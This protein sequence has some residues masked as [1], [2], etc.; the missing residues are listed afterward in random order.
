MKDME[1]FKGIIIA[2]RGI[3][4]NIHVYENTI[5]AF[6]KAIKR[7]IPIE[8][9]VH[10]LKDNKLVVFHDDNL[11]R[12]TGIK[13]EI[14]SLT[15]TELQNIKIK[16]KYSIPLFRDVLELV[17]GKVLLAIEIKDDKRVLDTCRE[18]VK[19]LD[20]YN[21]KF[22][23]QSFYPK[24][25]HWLKCYRKDYISGLLIP[26]TSPKLY[27]FII[28]KLLH[29]PILSP[30]F[31]ACSKYTLT[32]ERMQKLR[33]KIP[34]FVWTIQSKEELYHYKNYADGFIMNI[35]Y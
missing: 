26:L 9:D 5:E 10:L 11:K 2:H 32:T 3:H 17:D 18:L 28:H 25:I 13:K 33:K 24:Y 35:K 15:Y 8:L 12:L 29:I 16:D 4:D 14:R 34:L 20:P 27:Q 1:H 30:D 21:G 23:I 31:I 19:L 7:N 6:E 22:V